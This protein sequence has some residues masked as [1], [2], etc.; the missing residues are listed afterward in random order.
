M[1][2]GD[3]QSDVLRSG[4]I[5]RCPGHELEVRSHL[6]PQLRVLTMERPQLSHTV[7]CI[8]QRTYVYFQNESTCRWSLR[9]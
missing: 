8:N 6:P 1:N 2:T 3:E 4:N 9:G 5:M 7:H